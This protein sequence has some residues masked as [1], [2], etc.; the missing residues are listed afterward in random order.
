MSESKPKWY[1]SVGEMGDI[2]ISSRIR[3][4]RNLAEHPFPARLGASAARDILDRVADFITGSAGGAEFELVDLSRADALTIGSLVERHLIS[5][6]L[7]SKGGSRGAVLSRDESVSVMINEEDHLRIQ[8]LGSGLCLNECMK[9]A[10]M[11]DDLLEGHFSYAWDDRLGYLTHCPTN[12]GTGLRASVMLHLPAHTDTGEI[13]QLAATLGKLGFAVR[14]LYGEGSAAVGSMFQ[15]SNQLTLGPTEQ[16]TLDRLVQVVKSTIDRERFLRAKMEEEN[17]TF[18][19]D[20]VWRAYG[21]LKYARKISAGE[22]M[23]LLSVVRE[24][25]SIGEI[26]G[27]DMALL[28]RLIWSIQPNQLCLAAGRALGEQE[29]DAARA[30]YIRDSI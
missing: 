26:K 18:L 24:G 23:E 20:K 15:V 10:D 7:A 17:P 4:A 21:I 29:R 11:L 6:E 27:V 19:P 2:V 8:V 14:G 3:L 13:R 12:L 25:V 22:A 5:P 9:K 30:A 16:E 1:E 28:N